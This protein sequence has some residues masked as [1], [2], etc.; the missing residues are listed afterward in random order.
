[1]CHGTVAL[2]PVRACP[3]EPGNFFLGYPVHDMKHYSL[4]Q[5]TFQSLVPKFLLII[6]NYNTKL[7]ILRGNLLRQILKYQTKVL[8]Y[9]IHTRNLQCFTNKASE[10]NVSLKR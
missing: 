10:S 5:V 8:R 3:N 6:S 9:C 7:A 2:R 4:F 1:M